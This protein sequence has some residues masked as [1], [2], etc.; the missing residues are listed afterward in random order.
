MTRAAARLGCQIAE[1][2]LACGRRKDLAHL[3]AANHHAPKV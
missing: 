2:V 3:D 1:N